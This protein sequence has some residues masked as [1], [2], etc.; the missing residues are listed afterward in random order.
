MKTGNIFPSSLQ[1][2][3]MEDISTTHSNE[4][5]ANGQAIK[6]NLIQIVPEQP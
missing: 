2:K 3:K 6:L 5:Q 4:T 1:L